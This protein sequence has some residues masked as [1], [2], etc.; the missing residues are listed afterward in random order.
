M[1]LADAAKPPMRHCADHGRCSKH[2]RV[3]TAAGMRTGA[4]DAAAADRNLPNLAAL[5]CMLDEPEEALMRL[6]QD[7]S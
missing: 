7:L 3:G 4:D 2:A 6:G 5:L 1:L